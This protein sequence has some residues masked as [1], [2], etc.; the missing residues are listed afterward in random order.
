MSPPVS[1]ASS[2]TSGSIPRSEVRLPKITLPKFAGDVSEWISFRDMFMTTIHNSTTLSD[3]QKFTYLQSSLVGNAAKIVKSFEITDVNYSIAWDNVMKRYE[4]E[5]ELYFSIMRK[6]ISK[7]SVSSESPS[8]LRSLVDSTNECIRAIGSLSV[9]DKWD[10]ILVF[11]IAQKLDP[12]SRQFWELT[13]SDTSIPTSKSLID[14]IEQRARSLTASGTKPQP[15]LSEPAQKRP[16]AFHI[17]AEKHFKPSCKICNESHPH[18]KCDTLLNLDVPSR[19]RKVQESGLCPNCLRS[20]HDVTSCQSRGSCMKCQRKHHSILHRDPSNVQV[21]LAHVN[22]TPKKSTNSIHP[23]SI[24]SRSSVSTHAARPVQSLSQPTLAKETILATAIVLAKGKLDNWIPL[25]SLIDGGATASFIT[26]RAMNRLGISARRVSAEIKGFGSKPSGVS[27][28]I[29]EV[30]FQSRFPKKE[31]FHLPMYVMDKLTDNIP[32]AFQSLDSWTHIRNLQLADPKFNQ[33]AEIDILLG[34]DISYYLLSGK[35]RKKGQHCPVAVHSKLGWIISG[36]SSAPSNHVQVNC[37]ATRIDES[38][39]KFWELESV[40]AQ[41]VLTK[42][43]KFCESHFQRH[44]AREPTGRYVVKIPMKDPIIPLGSSREAAVRRLLQVERRLLPKPKIYEAYVEFM[45]QYEFLGHMTR[46][47]GPAHANLPKC[48]FLPHHFVVK[49]E[50]TLNKFRVVFDASAKTSSGF[51]FNE[52]QHVGPTIQ[53]TLYA[54]LLRFRIHPVGFTADIGKMYRQVLVHPE[55]RHLQCIVWRESPKYPVQ[56]YMLNT[57]TYGTA[58][59]PFLATRT[60]QQ[61]AKDEEATYPLASTIVKRDFYVDDCISG[62]D[63]P[64][65]AKQ[66]VNQLRGL[67]SSAHMSLRKFSSNCPSI[68]KD[69][70]DELKETQFILSLDEES[71]LV[72][73]LGLHWNTKT[74]E[75]LFRVT[76]PSETEK[77]T[78]RILLSQI[79]TLFDPM[80]WLAPTIIK[81]KL[82]MQSLWKEK[83]GGTIP[84]HLI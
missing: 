3:A 13:L 61:L 8:S 6:F 10:A 24:S 40:P 23:S 47:I 62:A 20:G 28:F 45:R 64:E 2:S 69:I 42:E 53:D 50:D 74:D 36:T 44:H 81:T 76:L 51:S 11:L 57:V 79:S 29:C 59:A 46:I 14:F 63:T 39:Q 1:T 83:L 26:T 55:Q 4:N 19:I 60:L 58:A 22:S 35:V 21:N 15:T 82:M 52:A 70:P 27:N 67:C 7:S 49:D 78:K 33:P 80:G 38:I 84:F 72:K 48:N 16:H 31:Q 12:T 77:I 17:Q 41:R 43:E 54:I 9:A 56:E 66:T 37:V 65:L 34:A 30:T 75:F 5:R 25:R 68:L 71:E 73:A 32:S 18:F